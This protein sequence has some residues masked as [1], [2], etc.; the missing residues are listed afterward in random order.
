MKITVE[1]D[2]TFAN[3]VEILAA[4]AGAVR[5]KKTHRECQD[6]KA[7]TPRIVAVDSGIAAPVATA[8]TAPTAEAQTEAVTEPAKQ[9]RKRRTKAQIEADKLAAQQQVEEQARREEAGEPSGEPFTVRVN[10]YPVR[11]TQEKAEEPAAETATPETSETSESAEDTGTKE[12]GPSLEDVRRAI[13]ACATRWGAESA[14]A[15]LF[16]ATGVK[17]ASDIPVEKYQA[18]IDRLLKHANKAE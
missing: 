3:D 14:I 9:K 11:V 15:N 16:L 8:P 6:A 18:A 17:K 5:S 10:E 13:V 4:I 12:G 7:E 2:T 1:L